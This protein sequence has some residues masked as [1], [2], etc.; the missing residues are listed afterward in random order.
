MSEIVNLIRTST[1]KVRTVCWSCDRS[2]RPRVARPDGRPSWVDWPRG[3]SET[4]AAMDRVNH[5]GSTGPMFTCPACARLRA[6]RQA[7]GEDVLLAPSPRRAA[8]IAV[9]R[10]R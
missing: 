8:A 1:G 3:W 7:A 2:S 4:P 10:G 6:E 9:R 5:D